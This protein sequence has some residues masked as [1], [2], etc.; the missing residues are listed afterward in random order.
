MESYRYAT[1]DIAL[2]L[3]RPGCSWEMSNLTI[4]KW[5]DPR[6]CPTW[7]EISETVDKIKRFEESLDTIWLD[8][9]YKE[10]QEN[11]KNFNRYLD[12]Q[13]LEDET[14]KSEENNTTI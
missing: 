13:F 5:N 7:E 14:K 10:I 3:L 8:E 11:Y 9:D 4:T 12:N 2:Q 6:P 1:V